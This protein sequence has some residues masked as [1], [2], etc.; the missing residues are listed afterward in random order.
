MTRNSLK[1][2]SDDFLDEMIAARGAK[3]PKF[4]GLVDEALGRRRMARGLAERRQ[5]LG[6]SQTAVAARMRTSASV[7]SKLEGGADVRLSTLQKYAAA[8]GLGLEVRL[9]SA[10]AASRKR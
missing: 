10:R 5:A 9:K 8:M 4:A 2:R 7:V 3:N 6:A 1:D